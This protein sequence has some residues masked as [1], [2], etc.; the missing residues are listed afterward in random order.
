MHRALWKRGF[1]VNPKLEE[2]LERGAAAH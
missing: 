2:E 1:A